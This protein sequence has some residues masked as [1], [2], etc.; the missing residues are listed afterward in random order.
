MK[1]ER[2]AH[3]ASK[4]SKFA[5]IKVGTANNGLFGCM[6][7]GNCILMW[8]MKNKLKLMFLHKIQ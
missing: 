5:K 2:T 1:S 8:H 3:H 7:N 6:M 4:H